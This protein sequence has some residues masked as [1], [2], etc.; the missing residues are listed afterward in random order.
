M[1]FFKMLLELHE[2]CISLHKMTKPNPFAHLLICT[3]PRRGQDLSPLLSCPGMNL[4]FYALRVPAT[5]QTNERIQ[6]VSHV[7][8]RRGEFTGY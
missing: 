6:E 7:T 2:L 5:E 3:S 1:A 4:L 8:G